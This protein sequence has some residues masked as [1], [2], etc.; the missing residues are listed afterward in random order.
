MKRLFAVLLALASCLALTGCESGRGG[1]TS[2]EPSDAVHP[3]G[4]DF[5]APS[6]LSAKSE[7]ILEHVWSGEEYAMPSG[8][9]IK[10]SVTPYYDPETGML[11]CCGVRHTE[12]DDGEDHPYYE[13]A[14]VTHTGKSAFATPLEDPVES[15]VFTADRFWYLRPKDESGTRCYDL[16]RRTLADGETESADVRDFFGETPGFNNNLYADADGDIWIPSNGSVVCVSPELELLTSVVLGDTRPS[17]AG[18]RQDGTFFVSVYTPAGTVLTAIDKARGRTGEEL[19]ENGHMDEIAFLDRYDYVYTA[20]GG[21]YG[22]TVTQKHEIAA[23]CLLDYVNSGMS[24]DRVSLLLL[25]SAD[26]MLFRESDGETS[27]PVLCHPEGSISLADVKVLEVAFTYW[28][29]EPAIT[30]AVSTFN[31]RH[32]DAR[33]VLLDYSVYSKDYEDT[34]AQTRLAMDMVTGICS[35]DIVLGHPGQDIQIEQILRKKL[36][37]DLGPY[38]DKDPEVNR[39]T[40]CGAVLSGFSDDDGKIWG[41]PRSFSVRSICA[42]RAVLDACGMAGKNGWDLGTLLDFAENLPADVTLHERLTRDMAPTWLLGNYGLGAFFD[43]REDR[44]AFDS[45]DFVRYL[46]FL[47]SLP[48]DEAELKRVSAVDAAN[49]AARYDYFYNDKVALQSVWADSDSMFTR[50]EGT[51]GTKNW[52]LIGFPTPDGAGSGLEVS[53]GR[54]MCIT[55]YCAE[56]DLAWEFVRSVIL[57]KRTMGGMDEELSVLRERA[58][59]MLHS[60]TGYEIVQEFSG[61][62]SMSSRKS[63]PP[64]TSADLRT[65]GYIIDFTDEDTE[66]IMKILDEDALRISHIVPEEVTEIVNE[67][68]SAFLGG[69]GSAEDCAKKIQSR[70]SIWLSE[71]S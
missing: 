51:F 60:L 70:V 57:S 24:A 65:P 34:T 47:R 4:S 33:I 59:K 20:S 53:A 56:P 27:F 26:A 71:H 35:P 13:Y 49:G 64:L 55:N 12:Y 50:F 31:R 67:E 8:W 58:R 45:P 7:G 43:E 14:I 68:I 9:S 16:V 39:E 54:V 37:R 63:D 62:T 42:N 6:G 19:P 44:C 46:D 2:A 21:V 40:V 41:L 18:L 5:S 10:A 28:L 15:G 25:L 29:Y 30:D 66:R 17:L 61:S 69:V 22:A 11:T 23:E 3:G 1:T 48:K 36:Y 38:L 32:T 52:E